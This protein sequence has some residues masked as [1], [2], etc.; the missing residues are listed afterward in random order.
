[1]DQA[2]SLRELM[3]EKSAGEAATPSKIAS[4]KMFFRRKISE[5][6]RTIA[7]T[8]GKGG[9]GKTNI[10]AN[11]ACTL[12]GMSKK[13]LVLDADAG[14]A[15]IDVVLG[16]TPKYN[17]YHVLA[18]ECTLSEVLVSGP[19]GVKILPAASGIQEMTDLS[20][21]QKLT[22]LEDLDSIEEKHDFMLIDTAAGIASNVMYFNMAA[23]EIIVVATPEPTSLTDAYAL[24]KV[25]QQR[26]AKKRFR[27]LINMVSS[28]AEARSVYLRLSHATEHFL[29]VTIEYLGYILYDKRLQEAVRMQR[30]FVELYPRSAASLCIKKVAEKICS[31][32][33]EYDENGN[34]SFFG[35]KTL[36]NERRAKRT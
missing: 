17:L 3:R 18:G 32:N 13:T 23:R 25:L 27:I 15:N 22:L 10:T 16:L 2:E 19:C 31:E 36:G 11:L 20:R 21:G 1:M 30:A 12:A 6:V 14:L 29:S 24:I 9:V 5:R 26:Y 4:T 35:D 7:I 33:P 34:I 8:S 28:A